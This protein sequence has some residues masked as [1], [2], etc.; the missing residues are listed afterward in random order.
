MLVATA[1]QHQLSCFCVC[2]V[3][4]RPPLPG[5]TAALPPDGAAAAVA[6]ASPPDGATGLPTSNA[7]GNGIGTHL[8]PKYTIPH[9]N[10]C[11]N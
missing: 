8:I 2:I 3:K 9:S 10:P 6:G 1:A 11:L 5:V 7:F 4:G